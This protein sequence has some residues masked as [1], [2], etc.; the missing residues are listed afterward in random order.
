MPFF[1]LKKK[2]K[3]KPQ[4]CYCKPWEKFHLVKQ[5][6]GVQ[7]RSK[8]GWFISLAL[9]IGS[10]PLSALSL[11]ACCIILGLAPS[12]CAR[13]LHSHTSQSGT[14]ALGEE[15]LLS[16]S[17]FS[18]SISPGAPIPSMLPSCLIGHIRWNINTTPVASKGS[19]VIMESRV[20]WFIPLFRWGCLL[21]PQGCNQLFCQKG[22][23]S[24]T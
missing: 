4:S 11:L 15:R 7:K 18:I 8:D 10:F 21:W 13:Q 2:K 19:R 3:G 1:I 9:R 14:S 17:I 5:R 24:S 12:V 16:L 23:I 22:R 6:L 20:S